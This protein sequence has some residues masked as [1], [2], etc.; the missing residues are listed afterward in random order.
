[1][2]KTRIPGCFELRPSVI[3]DPRGFFSKVFHRPLWKDFGLQTVFAE[4][5]VTYSL[6]W[7]MRGLHF[8]LP[9]MAHDKVVFCLKGNAFDVAIDLRKGSPAYG[10]HVAVNLSSMQSNALYVPAGVAHGFCVTGEEAL[11]YYKLTTSIRHNMMPVFVGIRPGSHGP[12][13]SQSCPIATSSCPDFRTSIAPST[14]EAEAMPDPSPQEHRQR[15]LVTGST[16]SIGSHLVRHLNAAGWKCACADAR[17]SCASA[18]PACHRRCAHAA[19]HR[20]TGRPRT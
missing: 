13:L 17:R 5:Y 9:P 10:D 20:Y 6:P 7:T 15:C 12:S 4:E 14:F 16:G 8:Q 11:L 2:V 18:L 1:M 3:R 19:V